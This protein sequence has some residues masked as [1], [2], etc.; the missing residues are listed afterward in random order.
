M[1]QDVLVVA[2]RILKGIGQDREAV[3][4]TVGID[5]FGKGKDG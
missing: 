2:A 5:T 1:A 3:K 4:G